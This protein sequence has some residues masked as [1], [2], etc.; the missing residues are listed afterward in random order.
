M[1]NIK[2]KPYSGKQYSYQLILNHTGSL[3]SSADV[4]LTDKADLKCYSINLKK[5]SHICLVKATGD[6]SLVYVV[7]WSIRFR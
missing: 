5:L 3:L 6:Q 4:K 1:N 2:N 7:M